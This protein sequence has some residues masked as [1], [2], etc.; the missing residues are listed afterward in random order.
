[1]CQSVENGS[2]KPVRKRPSGQG[3]TAFSPVA[4]ASPSLPGAASLRR[5]PRASIYF[6]F[7]FSISGFGVNASPKSSI[8]ITLRISTC[9]SP[10]G[11]TFGVRFTQGSISA[12]A[13]Q[14][15]LRSVKVT[16]PREQKTRGTTPNVHNAP[17]RVVNRT[18]LVAGKEPRTGFPVTTAAMAEAIQVLLP[19]QLA[20]W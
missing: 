11:K 15:V 3:T 18:K 4:I 8:S 9:A 12:S 19:E 17:A 10:F 7:T 6:I 14:A 1:M 2:H 16:N 20:T 13:P 5:A